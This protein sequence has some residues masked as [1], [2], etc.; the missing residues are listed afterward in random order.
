MKFKEGQRV[1]WTDPDNDIGSGYGTVEDVRGR[2]IA[3]KKDDG[4]EVEAVASEL[5]ESIV[6]GLG[7]HLIGPS[8]LIILLETARYALSDAG[9]FDE[10]AEMLDVN[11]DNMVAL[12][13][14]LEGF[15]EENK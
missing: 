12:C 9:I 6:E 7:K 2:I 15:L 13:A 1:Y 5:S 8:D 14:K 11:D 10:I 4:G 3:I